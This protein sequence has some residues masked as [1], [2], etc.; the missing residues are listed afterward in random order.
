MKGNPAL[1]DLRER[2]TTV[3]DENTER[4]A[5]HIGCVR[6]RIN[7]GRISSVGPYTQDIMASCQRILAAVV[8]LITIEEA[9]KALGK[10]DS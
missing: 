7:A 9:E 8:G 5:A 6:E 1:N 4:V 3:I 10:E 2:H